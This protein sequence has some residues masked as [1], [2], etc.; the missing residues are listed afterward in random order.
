MKSE[1][2]QHADFTKV[3]YANCWE[4]ADILIKALN[5]EGR[6]CI[7]IGSAGDN[8]FSLLAAGASHVTITEMNPAQI[9]CIKLRIAAYKALDHAEF[10]ILLGEHEGERTAL[11]E[12]CKPHLDDTTREYWEHFSDHISEGFGRV[13][14][15]ESYFTL[16]RDKMLPLVHS[17]QKIRSLL[18]HLTPETRHQFYEKQWN[19]WRWRLLFKI[20]FSRFVMGKLGRDPAFFKYVEGSVADRILARTRHALV[21]L[22]PSQ[23]PYLSWILTGRFGKH[24]PHALRE[25]NYDAI[26]NN[27][28]HITVDPRPL[29]AVLEGAKQPFDAYNLSDI[30]EY[31]SE[32]N[33]EAILKNI[34]QHSNPGAR[35]AYWNMLAPRSRPEKLAAKINSLTDL[36]ETLFKQDKAF[37]YSA[38]IVEETT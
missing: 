38:F 35:I 8:S 5:P 17:K 13:G 26:R 20:F 16:F 10:L 15:F 6:H 7:S 4:D 18:E 32:E 29:E 33:T 30:F 36:S 2:Q 24:R 19:T 34:H 1:I 14:K 11:Y 9:A 31:M 27:I 3:R 12:K 28:D 21:A 37:F 23:N 22:D 25:E